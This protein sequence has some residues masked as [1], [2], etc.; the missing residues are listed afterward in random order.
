MTEGSRASWRCWQITVSSDW[1]TTIGMIVLLVVCG[2]LLAQ[3][4]ENFFWGHLVGPVHVQRNYWS[5]W[6]KVVVLGVGAI[7]A[8]TFAFVFAQKHVKVACVLIALNMA[9]YALLSCFN[10]SPSVRHVVAVSGSIIHQIA[11]VIFCIAIVQWF[12]HVVRWDTPP[13]PQGGD[14]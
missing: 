11:L 10:I 2:W 8:F 9:T 13:A 14:R 7:Y 1:V 3:D 12:K 6:N 5:I 4:I